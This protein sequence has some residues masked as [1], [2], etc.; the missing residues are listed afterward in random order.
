MELSL[1]RYTIDR[2]EDRDWAVL[3]NDRAE[4]FRVPRTWL[5]AAVREGDVVKESQTPEGES[6]TSLRF[7]LDPAS[8]DER[9]AEPERLAESGAASVASAICAAA[10]RSGVSRWQAEQRDGK[11]RLCQLWRR[12]LRA[13]QRRVLHESVGESLSMWASTRFAV[14]ISVITF[15]WASP[16]VAQTL[17]IYHIDVEQAD[18]ALV[19]MPNGRTLLVDSGK[20][21][22]GQR[23]RNVMQQAGVT[24][25][26][27]FVNSHYHEDHFGGIDDLVEMGVPVLESYDRG[28]KQCCL[29]QSKKNQPTFKDYMRTVGED[30][31]ALRPG[32]RIALDPLVTIT[33][34]SSGGVV[35]GEAHPVPGAEENDLSVSLLLDFQGFKAF[36]GGD[37]EQPTEAK[38]AALHLVRDVDLYKA[39]H[40]GSHSSS[41]QPF[42]TEL[43]P[44]VVVISNGSDGLYK[45]PRQVTLTTYGTLPSTVFQTNKCFQPAP[46]ANVPDM[47]IADPQTVDQDGTIEIAVD[48][49]TN[50]YTV[51]FGTTVAGGFKVKSPMAPPVVTATI[52]IESLK[53]NPVGN[54]EQLEEVTIRNKGTTSVS[55]VGWTL[56][57]RSGGT[58]ML[59]GPLAPNQSRTF[60]RNGQVMSLNNA[61]DE[62]VLLDAA[63]AQRDRFEYSASSEGVAIGTQH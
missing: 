62:I 8:R 32:D 12:E 61:G 22:M 7:E 1:R 20:N 5:P 24:Q 13:I 26:D 21:G 58:W 50:T 34:I 2:F 40:H 10:N 23:I 45:H 9:P 30:A 54:D 37:I 63:S 11:R 31:I 25:I 19:V 36:F 14:L 49:T 16:L 6:A 35:I 41:S 51:R 44:S 55:L 53:P 17:R 18:A 42:M 38:I 39:D 56:Q 33:T 60:L 28:D 29:P 47:F 48:G 15:G 57:D 4:T 59:V 27:A 43:N 52:V 3:E 46:C